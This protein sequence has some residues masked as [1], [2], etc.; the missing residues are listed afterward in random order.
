MKIDRNEF[1]EKL[2]DYFGSLWYPFELS[3]PYED[4]NF[5]VWDYGISRHILDKNYSILIIYNP[6]PNMINFCDI[7]GT[8]A[9]KDF[10]IESLILALKYSFKKFL[11]RS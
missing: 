2:E 7:T 9:I 10:K 4:E 5:R 8:E 3:L 11:E 6:Y 1:K